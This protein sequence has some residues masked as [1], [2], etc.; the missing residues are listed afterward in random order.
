MFGCSP[1]VILGALVLAFLYPF[2]LVNVAA[3]SFGQLGLTTTGAF[4]LLGASLLGGVINLPIS[5]RVVLVEPARRR[6]FFGFVFYYPPKVRQQVIAINLGGA[7]I[8]SLFSLYLLATVAPLS[9]TAIA[10]AIV[11]V[12]SKALARIVPG[13]G[14]TMPGFVP[15]L[16][17]AA[18]A[19][20]VAPGGGAPAIAYIAGT[21]GT[22]IGADLLNLPAIR[23]L[24]AQ[25]VSIGGAGVF[26]GV[27]LS[28]IIAVLL[29]S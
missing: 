16:V 14:I 24:P 10:T 9:E 3:F 25:M 18:A 6:W 20:L 17:S 23:R 2:I 4:I 27:F 19:L 13:V 7:V 8:P 12:I 11:A 28:G 5:R 22:L 1:L 21:M 26:D 15:P 29:T